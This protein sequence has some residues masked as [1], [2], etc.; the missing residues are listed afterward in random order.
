VAGIR[1]E[2][3]LYLYAR[4]VSSSDEGAVTL[5]VEAGSDEAEAPSGKTRYHPETGFQVS[6]GGVGRLAGRAGWLAGW[7][8]GCNSHI[9]R[10]A[11]DSHGHI[12]FNEGAYF[13]PTVTRD[14]PRVKRHRG[15]GGRGG[16]EQRAG[17]I[18]SALRPPTLFYAYPCYS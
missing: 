3:V 8:A 12:F 15:G 14:P 1:A 2:S 7:L 4:L 18:H 6:T 5:V 11:L 10:M 16:E 9:I 13:S 17:Q